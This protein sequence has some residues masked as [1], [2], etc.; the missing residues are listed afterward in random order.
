MIRCCCTSCIYCVDNRCERE[1]ILMN[2]QGFCL[3]IERA[4]G[5]D[6]DKYPSFEDRL[7][8]PPLRL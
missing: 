3:S 7:R 2:E 5:T 8:L 6:P 1:D 4:S